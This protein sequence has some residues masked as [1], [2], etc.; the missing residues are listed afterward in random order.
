MAIIQAKIT[1]AE[2]VLR[3]QK[4]AYQ[5][6]AK[7]YNDYNIPPLKQTIAEIKEQFKTY[8]IL[9]AVSEKQIIGT[10][11]AYEEDGTCFVGKLA[12][13]PDMQNQGIGAALMKE[14]EK[15]FTP[16]RFELFVGS[17]SDNNIHLYKKLGYNIY[18]TG[19]YDCDHIEIIY[20]EKVN[21]K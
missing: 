20:M 18:K 7:R 15:H 9:K 17:K 14:I 1:D 19:G 11:R 5:I 16:K 3:L 21:K 8:I 10:V 4:L 2:E 6:E 12:V 13:L